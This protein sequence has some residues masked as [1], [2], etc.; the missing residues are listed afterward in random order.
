MVV[1]FKWK[2]IGEESEQNDAK[3]KDIRL[4]T[5]ISLPLN[6]FRCHVLERADKL[7]LVALVVQA[8]GSAKVNQLNLSRKAHHDVLQFE[9]KMYDFITVNI[10]K[11]LQNMTKKVFDSLFFDVFSTITQFI[12]CYTLNV[13]SYQVALID[14]DS[15]SLDQ[16]SV[17]AMLMVRNDTCMIYCL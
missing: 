5:V 7:R 9:V 3:R 13:L 8:T 17:K 1:A 2:V 15:V 12:K 16:Y 14:D 10:V 4:V 6:H 11:C